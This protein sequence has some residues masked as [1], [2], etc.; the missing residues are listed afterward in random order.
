VE[1][2][3]EQA[4]HSLNDAVYREGDR[5]GPTA[6]DAGTGNITVREIGDETLH[7]LGIHVGMWIQGD[8]QIR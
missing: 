3:V 5:L 4:A 7:E 8:N 1:L 6:F 2:A